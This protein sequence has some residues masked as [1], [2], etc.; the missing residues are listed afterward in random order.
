[1]GFFVEITKLSTNVLCIKI[2]YSRSDKFEKR[3]FL[4]SDVHWDNPH[5]NRKLLTKHL[6]QV[7]RKD[8]RIIDVG[9]F[10][11]MMGGKFDPRRSKGQI[12]PEFNVDNYYDAIIQA[13]A[14]YLD[15][16]AENFITI[17]MGNHET[18]VLKN[19]EI[20]PTERLISILNSRNKTNIFNGGYKGWVF[21][22]FRSDADGGGKTIK[23]HYTHG[24]GGNAPVTKGT[25]KPSR[26]GLILPDAD[27]V[28]SGH[29]HNRWTFS[30]PRERVTS[31]GRQY[32][33]EQL[34]IQLPTYKDEYMEYKGW[35]TEREMPP[36]ALGGWWLTF[37]YA[38][39][40]EGIKFDIQRAT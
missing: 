10:F 38:G 22:R 15:P 29:I 27:I 40:E 36:A 33:D 30:I 26:R 34:H 19:H 3:F 5:C 8:A 18:A 28:V 2:T 16:Y 13:A 37:Y 6:E 17:G 12:R 20:N 25:L 7:K 35:A 32:L 9:D 4:L 14:D 1:M 39:K 31:T 11:D 23:L 24:S 21:F